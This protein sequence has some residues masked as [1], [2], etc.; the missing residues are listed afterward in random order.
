MFVCSVSDDQYDQEMM[1]A[2]RLYLEVLSSAIQRLDDVFE[3]TDEES[4]NKEL[5]PLKMFSVLYQFTELMYTDP[6]VKHTH[7]LNPMRLYEI[8]QDLSSLTPLDGLNEKSEE[9]EAEVQDP[10]LTFFAQQEDPLNM[11][12]SEAEAIGSERLLDLF[13]HPSYKASR[14]ALL[15]LSF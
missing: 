10:V 5:L 14:F 9:D 7:F 3:G 4:T 12:L 6:C 11:T 1:R 8:V 15:P 13:V 2:S